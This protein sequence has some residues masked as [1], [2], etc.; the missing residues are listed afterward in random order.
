M[1]VHKLSDLY[2]GDGMTLGEKVKFYR[3]RANLTQIQLAELAG[4]S[5]SVIS[6]LERGRS[7]PPIDKMIIIS[8]VLDMALPLIFSTPSPIFDHD[9][10]FKL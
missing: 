8:N 7:I 10:E 3:K 9:K 6:N 4:V 5:R 2:P 1:S